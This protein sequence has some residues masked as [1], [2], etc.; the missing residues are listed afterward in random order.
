MKLHICPYTD[1]YDK[2][3]CPH[4]VPHDP[5]VLNEDC[6]TQGCFGDCICQEINDGLEEELFEI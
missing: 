6:L 5:A 1:C 3:S 4:S 2:E